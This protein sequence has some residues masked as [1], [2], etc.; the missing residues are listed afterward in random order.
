MN[1]YLIH[2]PVRPLPDRF[3]VV[4]TPHPIEESPRRPL[5]HRVLDLE[6]FAFEALIGL[7]EDLKIPAPLAGQSI[8]DLLTGDEGGEGHETRHDCWQDPQLLLQPLKEA[9]VHLLAGRFEEGGPRTLLPVRIHELRVRPLNLRARQGLGFI[10]AAAKAAELRPQLLGTLAGETGLCPRKF[11]VGLSSLRV[12]DGL[13]SF[14][15]LLRQLA[16]EIPLLGLNSGQPLR[17]PAVFTFRRRLLPN[18]VR[19]LRTE[20]L[21]FSS[22]LRSQSA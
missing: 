4:R 21:D 16:P 2:C 6:D 7:V 3:S 18:S 19:M 13:I 14:P 11:S 5:E 22:K 9:E 1:P 8:H 10:H 20:M 15:P 17:Q 12:G